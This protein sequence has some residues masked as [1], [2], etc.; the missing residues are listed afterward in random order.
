MDIT[1]LKTPV[2]KL[3]AAARKDPKKAGV[4]GVLVLVMAGLWVKVLVRPSPAPAGAAAA[5]AA[6][7]PKAPSTAQPATLTDNNGRF[8]SVRHT[9]WTTVKLA[10]PDRNLFL[11]DYDRFEK[12]GKSTAN[13]APVQQTADSAADLAKS[14]PSQ[15]DLNKERQILVA[16]LQ[17]QAAQL[18]LRTTVMGP[19]PKALVNGTLVGEGDSVASFRVVKITPRGMV[20][21]REGI[22][23]EVQMK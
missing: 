9:S 15:A 4:L 23:L 11:I 3:R 19:S 12:S 2:A 18:K 20:I 5:H 6:T 22:K 13:G 10:P 8:A 21:E 1:T 17:T 16:N 7:G 14:G